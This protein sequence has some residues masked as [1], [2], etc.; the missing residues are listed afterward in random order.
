MAE[1][2]IKKTTNY[3]YMILKE[4]TFYLVGHRHSSCVP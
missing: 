4:F 3:K 1:M 2:N